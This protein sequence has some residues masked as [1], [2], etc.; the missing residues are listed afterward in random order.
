MFLP[1][2]P[3]VVRQSGP[4]CQDHLRPVPRVDSGSTEDT[5]LA[6]VDAV[7]AAALLSL[8]EDC[9]RPVGPWDY[10]VPWAMGPIGLWISGSSML[11]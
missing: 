7:D 1:L 8:E 9:P 2:S 11:L 5:G 4:R 10:G 6:E 3:L